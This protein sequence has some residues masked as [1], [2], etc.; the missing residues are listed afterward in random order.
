MSGR[1]QHFRRI[2]PPRRRAQQARAEQEPG[3]RQ[4]RSLPSRARPAPRI[5]PGGNPR[6]APDIAIPRPAPYKR[7]IR[8]ER[9]KR[10]PLSRTINPFDQT[11]AVRR[12][13]AS[14]APFARRYRRRGGDEIP[15]LHSHPDRDAGRNVL[16][17]NGLLLTIGRALSTKIALQ[18]NNT[19]VPQTHR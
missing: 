17:A 11:G 3:D 16:G 7:E 19:A 12:L 4:R 10:G 5:R 8:E 13:G 1:A 2:A 14:I 9:C 18:R 15:V 6:Q